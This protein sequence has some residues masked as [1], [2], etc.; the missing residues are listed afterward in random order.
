ML[1][2]VW[3]GGS[4]GA[5]AAIRAAVEA[6]EAGRRVDRPEVGDDEVVSRNL[7][8]HDGP[9]SDASKTKMKRVVVWIRGLPR[10]GFLAAPARHCAPFFMTVS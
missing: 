1:R 5:T 7:A 9:R 6:V 8:R 4:S 2:S 10:A 3:Y